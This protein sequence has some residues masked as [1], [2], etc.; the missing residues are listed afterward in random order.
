M[1]S[2]SK[3]LVETRERVTTVTINRPELRNA[4]DG[5]TAGLL[6]DA[7]RQFD[8]ADFS[9]RNGSSMPLRSPVAPVAIACIPRATARWDPAACCCPNP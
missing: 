2:M 7:F 5:E 4:V 6:A 1:S 9:S 8:A 3:V